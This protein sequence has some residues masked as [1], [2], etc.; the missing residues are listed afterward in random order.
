[1]VAASA[2]V[3]P[4]MQ[5]ERS[6]LICTLL[7]AATAQVNS[8]MQHVISTPSNGI[9]HIDF[10]IISSHQHQLKHLLGHGHWC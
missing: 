10:N 5:H 9:G 3:N 4:G 6:S 1:L 8:G 2:Q 7:T